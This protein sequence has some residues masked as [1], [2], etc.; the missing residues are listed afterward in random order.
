MAE[1]GFKR[2]LTAIL[3]ADVE[4]YSRLMGDDEEATVRTLT[5]YREVLSTLIQQHNGKV[6]D[7]PGDNLLAEFV[8]VV[9][10]VQC[11]VAVQKE[12]KARNEELPENRRMKFRIGINLGD[13]IQE[14]DRIYGDGVNIAARLEGLAEPGGICISKTAFDHIE[15]K[16][17]YGYDFIGDQTVKNIAKPVG[18]YRVLL[19][20]RVTVSGK[21]LDKKSSS[22]RRTPILVGS[23]AVLVLVIVIG[24]WQFYSRRPSVEPASLEKMEYPLPG[25]ASIVVLPFAN[26]SGDPKQD[27]FSDGITES[28]IMALSKVSDMFVIAR[29]SAFTYKGKAVKVKQV[30]EEL[31]VRY[32]LEGSV[33]K[34]ENRLRIIVQL[35]DA[36]KGNHMW[37]ERY[38]RDLKDLFALQDEITMKIITAL[39]VQLTEGEEINVGDVG[40]DNL[41]AYLKL[42]EA[43]AQLNRW[44]KEGNALC[45]KLAEEAVA[46]DSEFAAAYLTISAAHLMDMMYGSSESPKQSLKLAEKMVQKAISL[47]GENAYARGFLGRIYLT[48]RQYDKA[49]AEG[50]RAIALNPNSAFANAALAFSLYFAGR[51]Q[52][53]I[54]LYKKAIR[55]SPISDL[56]HLRGLGACYAREGRYEEAISEYKK[57]IRRN[58]DDLFA[59][60][61]SAAAYAIW[62][63]EKEAH[64]EA[65]EVLRID[66]KFALKSYRK[67]LLYK[68]PADLKHKI[69]AL[70]KAGLPE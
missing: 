42:M 44:N 24:T 7:S 49:I 1:E 58:P 38:D 63:R 54:V 19:D 35:I 23:A 2:K 36:I 10:G 22:I 55:L 4:G 30:A 20:P 56:W 60:V 5:S 69:N 61:E 18:A 48:K 57:A 12:I 15:S 8:S 68:N 65:A 41:V 25:K 6:L 67:G 11:A 31:G 16:L 62:G 39:Q 9:D 21:P 53:A 17:P 13:V 27:Y 34:T 50:E 47:R 51:P 26:M 14:E 70:R 45:R 59:H 28:I 33:Q 52:E 3:S 37:A 64:A 32:V 29:N 66:P 46:L 43:N 40:T